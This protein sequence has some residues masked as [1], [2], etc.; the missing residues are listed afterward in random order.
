MQGDVIAGD[1]V[2]A[3]MT[4]PL[5]SVIIATYN[6]AQ[7]LGHAIASV[8]AQTYT[9]LELHVVD[10]GSTDD[11]REIVRQFESDPRLTYSQQAN[12]GQ[13]LAKNRGVTESRGEFVAFCDA[14]DLW[15][16][17]KLSLQMPLFA[18]RER[19]GLVYSNVCALLPD[20]TIVPHAQI[21]TRPS[22]Q[23]LDTLFMYNFV[24]FGT[25]VVRRSCLDELGAFDV[26][27]R[28]SIDW[29]L[30]LRI[31]TRYEFSYLDEVTYIY[32]MWEGQMSRDW[33]GRYDHC[34]RIM[35]E[36]LRKYPTAVSSHVA[37]DAYVHSYVERARVRSTTAGEHAQ[38][39]LDIAKALCRSPTYLPAWKLIARV[40]LTMIGIRDTRPRVA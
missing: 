1:A 11:T 31:A 40:S 25:A 35:D 32:R 38:A 30:W 36:F 7:H 15:T 27:L 21:F 34:F 33:R 9:N 2:K 16:P 20:G 28:M 23:V 8:L 26:S 22:G 24:P 14:D 4:Q 10:D 37:R 6:M 5:V 17:A 19:V 39:F 29:E 3:D 12:A 18:G 13:T